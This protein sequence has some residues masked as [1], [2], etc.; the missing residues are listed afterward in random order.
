MPGYHD[1]YVLAKDRTAAV[2]SRFLECFVPNREQS[3]DNYLFPQYS[4]QPV[5]VIESASEAI[6]H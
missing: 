3:A 1:V 4:D 5:V 2:A 6:L